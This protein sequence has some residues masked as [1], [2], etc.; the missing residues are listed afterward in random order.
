MGNDV[1]KGVAASDR[2]YG[3]SGNDSLYGG[4]GDDRLYGDVGQDYIDGAAG[5]DRLYGGTES[6]RLLGQGGHDTLYGGVHADTLQGGDGNDKL[7]G[8]AGNDQLD[9]GLGNDAMSGGWGRDTFIFKSSL[10]AK[11]DADTITDF[12]VQDDTIRLENKLFVKLGKP[13]NLSPDFFTIG[14]KAQDRNDHLVYNKNTG[15]LYYDPDGSGSRQA[16]LFV[17]LKAD[18]AMSD[19]DFYII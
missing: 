15:H 13:G 7:Y 12:N 16:I 3:G 17:K 5:N 6:N 10:N 19:R 4:D 8:D 9:G 11:A 1:L 18:L 14:S 2:L